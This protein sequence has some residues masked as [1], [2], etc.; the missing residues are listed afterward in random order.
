MVFAG[1]IIKQ[2]LVN[3]NMDNKCQKLVDRTRGVVF[4]STPHLGAPLAGLGNNAKYLMLPSVE[5]QALS[6]GRCDE[7]TATNHSKQKVRG[8]F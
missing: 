4:Y 7:C 2:M 8:V 5:V 6:Y 3:S 1:L